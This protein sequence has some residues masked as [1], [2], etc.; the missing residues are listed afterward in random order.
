MSNTLRC[1]TV[2]VVVSLRHVY[3][4]V[5]VALRRRVAALH[6][7]I[8]NIDCKRDCN[9]CLRFINTATCCCCCSGARVRCLRLLAGVLGGRP[10]LRLYVRA[11]AHAARED[12][13]LMRT[14]CWYVFVEKRKI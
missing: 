13:T 8:S 6:H 5:A 9:F 4:S 10:L 14:A 1:N 3:M 2:V 11:S 7:R 12:V